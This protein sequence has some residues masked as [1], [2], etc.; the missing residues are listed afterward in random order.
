MKIPQPL[1]DKIVLKPIDPEDAVTK[2][3]LIL[4]NAPDGAFRGEVVAVGRGYL[5]PQTMD[6]FPLESKLGDIVAFNKDYGVTELTHN[7]EKFIILGESTI[8]AKIGMAKVTV[9]V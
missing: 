1:G 8:L 3:G 9:N 2:G 6:I 5:N 4:P 7:Q